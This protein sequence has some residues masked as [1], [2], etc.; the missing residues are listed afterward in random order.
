MID[1][2]KKAL[3]NY[4]VQKRDKQ[5][6]VFMLDGAIQALELLLKNKGNKDKK[7]NE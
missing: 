3:E 2:I 1:E 5:N 4:K 7:D 6:Q